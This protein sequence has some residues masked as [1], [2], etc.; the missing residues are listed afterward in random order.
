MYKE[1]FD[2]YIQKIEKVF[3]NMKKLHFKNRQ[4][5]YL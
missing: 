4:N 5:F 2:S 1:L 3:K